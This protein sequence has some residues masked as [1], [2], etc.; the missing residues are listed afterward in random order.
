[1]DA[2]QVCIVIPT[3]GRAAYLDTALAS[4]APQARAAGAELI[5]VNDGADPAVGPIA[6]RHGARLMAL[7]GPRGANAAR[8]AGIAAS[9]AGLVVLLDDDVRAPPG[10]LDALLDGAR[11]S[12]DIDVFGGPIRAVLEGG[13]PRGCGRENPPI[14]H[15][16]LGPR[17]RNVELVWSANMALR[18]RALERVGPFD[19]S[20]HGRGEEEDWERRHRAAGGTVRYLA[21]AGLEHRRCGADASLRRLARAAYRLGLTARHY[22]RRK[23]T[24]PSPARELWTLTATIGHVVRRRCPLGLVS[25]AHSLGRVRALTRRTGG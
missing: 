10:W 17:D 2:S 19:E 18:R 22:D 12:P 14:T 6:A 5:V 7:P 13:G 4:V 8:N 20:I 3:R 11:R 21:G 16:D 15:L 24:A 25:V 23:G 9:H 1:M